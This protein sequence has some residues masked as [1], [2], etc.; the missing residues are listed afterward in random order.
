MILNA[1]DDVKSIQGALAP[2]ALE[3]KIMLDP[4]PRSILVRGVRL[5]GITGNEKSA[6]IGGD[7]MEQTTRIVNGAEDHK[8]FTPLSEAGL[9][10]MVYW[11]LEQA[12]LSK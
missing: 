6:K 5:Y 3:K 1:E 4:L 12:K 9:F 8:R 7:L 10:D 2:H 11:S